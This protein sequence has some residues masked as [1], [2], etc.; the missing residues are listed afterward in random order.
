MVLTDD[1]KR[2]EDMGLK[3]TLVSTG[4]Y[5]GL[6]ADGKVSQKLVDKQQ[7]YVDEIQM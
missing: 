5:K 3:L 1:S 4:E 2:L 7:E 6:G